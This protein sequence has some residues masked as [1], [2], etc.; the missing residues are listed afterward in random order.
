MANRATMSPLLALEKHAVSNQHAQA[1]RRAV[2]FCK[3]SVLSPV[4][5]ASSCQS[6]VGSHGSTMSK[7]HTRRHGLA[8]VR[9]LDLAADCVAWVRWGASQ[10]ENKKSGATSRR[11]DRPSLRKD[12]F[13]LYHEP[14]RPLNVGNRSSRTRRA[15]AVRM[16]PR[17]RPDAR[18][19]PCCRL[20]HT[21]ASRIR[22]T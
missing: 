1:V 21:D 20:R 11:F 12:Y 5:E 8:P 19:R 6:K 3:S 9:G 18:A 16:A 14:E 2:Y 15:T 10:N 4:R 22:S 7:L 13:F 17:P